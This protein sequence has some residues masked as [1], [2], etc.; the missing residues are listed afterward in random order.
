[1]SRRTGCVMTRFQPF[2]LV[3]LPVA[4][5]LNISSSLMPR[6]FGRGTLN[7]A[8]FSALLFLIEELNALAVVVFCRSCQ[9]PGWCHCKL[10][11]TPLRPPKKN[12]T[13]VAIP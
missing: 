5:T 10:P 13:A 2:L 4:T 7:R 9:H 12:F 3:F 1:M 6:T 8:A 11:S